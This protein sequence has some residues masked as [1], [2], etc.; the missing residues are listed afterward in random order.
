MTAVVSDLE[1]AFQMVDAADVETLRAWSPKGV[2]STSKG[3]GTPVTEADVAAEQAML[4]VLRRIR[5]DDAFV[6]EETGELAGVTGRRWIAD[7]VD[8]T[9]FFA[10]GAATWGTLLALEIDGVIVA[11]VSSSPVQNRRWWAQRHGGAFTGACDGSSASRISVSKRTDR[12][13]ERIVCLPGFDGVPPLH[14]E[15]L[16][17]LVDGPPMDR[18]WSHQ[19]RVAE[20]EVDVCVWFAGDIWDHAAPSIIVEEAGGRFS[21]HWGGKRLDS[22]TA[23]YSNGRRHDEV[24]AALRLNDDPT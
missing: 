3:D 1:L 18:A 5:P 8:G 16:A 7:G 21:D 22:R 14:R 23:I 17:S 4:N 19:N 11:G 2:T 20:G 10:A 15:Q 9:R 24:L 12:D 13:P 6:G